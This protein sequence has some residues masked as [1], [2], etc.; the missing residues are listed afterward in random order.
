VAGVRDMADAVDLLIEAQEAAETDPALAK[1]RARAFA[2][3]DSFKR[4][5]AAAAE[6][7][8]AGVDAGL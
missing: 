5:Q 7:S 6:L 4:V 8:D 2:S 1:Q 3:D